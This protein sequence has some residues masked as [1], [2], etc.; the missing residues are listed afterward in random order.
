M[1]RPQKRIAI[2]LV[3][4]GLFMLWVASP[5]AAANP[6]TGMNREGSPSVH[7]GNGW[8]DPGQVQG[9]I[10]NLADPDC[11]GNR[12]SNPQE[13]NIGACDDPTGAADK[14][15]GPGGFDSDKDWNNGCGNDA[16]FE[17]DNNGMC[18]G[19]P[20][21]SVVG[22]EVPKVSGG[23]VSGRTKRPSVAGRVERAL[24]EGVA[25]TPGNPPV[26][27][28][29]AVL[30]ERIQK[31]AAPIPAGRRLAATGLDSM[32]LLFMGIA[33]IALGKRFSRKSRRV[34]MTR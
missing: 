13:T 25:V 7:P 1:K 21:P 32:D 16:D 23:E 10:K 29:A 26:V 3:I 22:K 14:L 18:G 31:P 19:K 5:A 12:T 30:M 8:K 24:H 9:S 6:G 15:D 28:P 2:L 33:L 11:T 17:D 27:R 34:A 4:S 20:G